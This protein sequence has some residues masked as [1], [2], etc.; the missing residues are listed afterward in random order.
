MLENTELVDP[1]HK[2]WRR[3]MI[4]KDEVKRLL[5]LN[6][7]KIFDSDR[8]KVF[9]N[10]LWLATTICDTSM[11]AVS[12][13]DTDR[14]Y[15]KAQ[16]G[17]DCK[18]TGRDEAFCSH[19]ILQKENLLVV[20]DA[21][22]DDR[23]A[24]NPLVTSG[25][26][27]RFYA[28][29]PLNIEGVSLGTLCVISENPKK[30]STKQ[31]I[32]LKNLGRLCRDQL[33]LRRKNLQLNDMVLQLQRSEAKLIKA[34]KKVM[35][36]S[37]DKEQF[38]AN[39]THELR[40]PLNAIVGF[41]QL[42]NE[43][44][45]QIPRE[46]NENLKCI[47][48]GS[49]VLLNTVNAVLDFTKVNSGKWNLDLS[50]I[51]I[52]GVIKSISSLQDGVASRRK[53]IFETKIDETLHKG[54]LMDSMKLT[55]I[56]NNLI[57][58]AMKFTPAGKKVTFKAQRRSSDTELQLPSTMINRGLVKIEAGHAGMKHHYL[59][60]EV[61]DEGCGI[62]PHK[63][64]KIFEAFQQENDSTSRTHGGTGLG[65]AIVKG[66]TALMKGRIYIDSEPD[67]GSTFGIIVPYEPC[68]LKTKEAKETSRTIAVPSN[69]RVFVAEDDFVSQKLMKRF[70]SKIGID[71]TMCDNG[72]IL[73]DSISKNLDES[74]DIPIVFTDINM[75]VMGG[76]EVLKEL[77]SL[78]TTRPLVITALTASPEALQKKNTEFDHVLGK[79]VNF[80]ALKALLRN[81]FAQATS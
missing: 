64:S 58:N 35:Q 11:G 21:L 37:R 3:A 6:D 81:L 17:L 78:P 79:P 51:D 43:S 74:S 1:K 24:D 25:P 71:A 75:P 16:K 68:A 40:T 49:R 63:F 41:M 9:D 33:V 38:L 2:R 69:C 61:K 42:M 59:L 48:F 72:R 7:M 31:R 57:S 10:I 32:A 5:L 13:I 80:K 26:N 62:D 27:I 18:Q 54:M 20:P 45:A 19:A 55:Q 53:V 76:V 70:F 65:L 14:Q 36:A 66:I 30:L 77:R 34:N 28:G 39:M 8:E 60:F 15:F 22:K 46:I 73:C 12:L 56:L 44:S 47:S 67:K 50:K 4:P 29:M 52:R 23:F